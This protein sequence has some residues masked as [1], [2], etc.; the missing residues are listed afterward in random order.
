MRERT[1]STIFFRFSF[2]SWDNSTARARET[3]RVVAVPV[4]FTPATTLVAMSSTKGV[5]RPDLYQMQAYTTI[6]QSVQSHQENGQTVIDSVSYTGTARGNPMLWV[7]T[8]DYP[9]R[10]LREEREGVTAV[11]WDVTADGRVENC[12]VTSSSGSPDLDQAAAIPTSPGVAATSPRSISPATPSRPRIRGGFAGR[13]LRIEPCDGL[14]ER[15]VRRRTPHY[16]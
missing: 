5:S 7:T 8:D 9:S 10:A 15:R 1:R 16:Y 6:S 11:A 14:A 13:C 2:S 3:L 12:R 4:L